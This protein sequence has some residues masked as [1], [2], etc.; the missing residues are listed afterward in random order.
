[1]K[2]GQRRSKNFKAKEGDNMARLS[3]AIEEFINT[4]MKESNTN[5]IE[6][7]RNELA[8]YFNC[9]PSQINYVLT[10]RFTVENG[11]IVESYRGGGGYIKINKLVIDERD[12]LYNLIIKE[13]G[14]NISKNKAERIILVLLKE[15]IID[16]REANIM[17]AAISDDAIISPLNLKNKIRAQILKKMLAVLM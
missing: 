8:K 13:I 6:I 15:N 11:Y 2:E 10:T 16:N 14:D 17:K 7:Q 9:S 4:L 1:M 5:K 12:Y 3:D